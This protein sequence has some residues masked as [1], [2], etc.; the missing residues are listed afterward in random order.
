MNDEQ[1]VVK[2]QELG[3]LRQGHFKL[4]SGRHSDQFLLCSQLTMQPTETTK[5]I[6][7]LA[8]KVRAAGLRPNVIV[9]PAM[10]G[11]ILAYEMARALG[12]RAMFAEKEGEGMA[13][14]RGFSLTAGD[15]VLVIE[16]AVS[17]GGSI[18]KV[19]DCLKETEAELL[20]V[21]VL[22]DR[23]KGQV[24]FDGKPPIALL[25]LSIASWDPADCPLCQA[26]IELILP[27]A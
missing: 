12:C 5:M 7:L 17:T 14:K 16:D 13:L 22:F 26:G 19:L 6:G 21:A 27:K 3:V 15:K 2:L 4:T 9:G 1:I 18:E 25:E 11:V 23:T 10:G 24:L 20:G 8:T